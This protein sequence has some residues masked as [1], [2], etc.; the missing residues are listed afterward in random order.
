M[1][2]KIRISSA[3]IRKQM[4]Q[5]LLSNLEGGTITGFPSAAKPKRSQRRR[6]KIS[7][8][9]PICCSCRLPWRSQ[10][11]KEFGNLIECSQCKEWYH[12]CCQLV[13]D[14]VFQDKSSVWSCDMCK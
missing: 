6:V 10:S 11:Y 8:D 9:I 14:L 13:P 2:A 7:R 3:L 4:R 5:H 1:Q 12:Q